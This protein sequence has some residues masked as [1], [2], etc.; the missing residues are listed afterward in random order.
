MVADSEVVEVIELGL[1]DWDADEDERVIMK[2]ETSE[3]VGVETDPPSG[4]MVV[5]V[6][7]VPSITVVYVVGIAVT[8]R[9]GVGAVVVIVIVVVG[10][11]SVAEGGGGVGVAVSSSVGE[12]SSSVLAGGVRPPYVHTPSVPKGI[13]II[14][15]MRRIGCIKL[16]T[17]GP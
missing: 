17:E 4:D 9:V 12:G 10:S 15:S 5:M 3:E 8:V 11:D 13:Y 1:E 14:V 16:L 7:K 2:E 6:V